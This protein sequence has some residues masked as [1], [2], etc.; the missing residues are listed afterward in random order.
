MTMLTGGSSVSSS[1][2]ISGSLTILGSITGSL[3]GTASFA[4]TASYALN[5]SS[6]FSITTGSV[7]AQVDVDPSSIFL[8]NSGSTRLLNLNNEGVLML[9]QLSSTPNA[10]TGGLYFDNTGNF[11]VGL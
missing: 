8:I 7:T 9:N 5:A 3:L 10:V 4:L 6:P 2:T 11:Y 1:Q